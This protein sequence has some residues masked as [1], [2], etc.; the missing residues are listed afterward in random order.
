MMLVLPIQPPLK[1]QYC[2]IPQKADNLTVFKSAW[3]WDFSSNRLDHP[4]T[5][6]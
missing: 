1:M 3:N 5:D 6:I 4:N 2:L